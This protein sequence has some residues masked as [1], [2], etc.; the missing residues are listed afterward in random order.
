MSHH[1]RILWSGGL[2]LVIGTLETGA[3]PVLLPLIAPEFGV[4]TVSVAWV[5]VAFGLGMAS[6]ALTA[7]RIGDVLGHK[8][9]AV[10]G[11]A[12]EL[13]L[14]LLSIVSPVFWLVLPL[15]FLQG[16]AR[17]AH[18]NSIGALIMGA[19]PKE[20]R[21]RAV[22]IRLGLA[23]VGLILGPLYA[24]LVAN[25]L[26]W[27][28]PLLG[29]AALY[30]AHTLAVVLAVP[31]DTAAQRV[32][33]VLRRLD[34]PGALAFLVS[35][36]SLLYG[37]QLLR[38]GGSLPQAAAFVALAL[39]AF[40]AAMAFERR[41][42]SPA[43]NLQVLGTPISSSAFASLISFSA[44]FGAVTF[45]MPFFMQRG[46]G[47]T[48]A[49]SGG[50]L[51]TLN[52]V[53]VFGAPLMGHLADRGGTRLLVTVGS[54]LVVLGLLLASRLGHD[55]QAWQV[56]AVML[57]L[58]LSQSLFETPINRIFYDAVPANALASAAAFGT[59]GRQIGLALGGA[60]GA[61]LLASRADGSTV[62]GVSAALVT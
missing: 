61:A 23:Y 25:G 3:W 62:A 53:Q 58:G 37:A 50:V 14:L 8:R 51:V 36:A 46:L 24:G 47:W 18:I 39:A 12:L 34:W 19:Y 48:V 55:T 52:L 16:I 60:L 22:G 27:R 9:V 45:L 44:A 57:L 43:L 4:S 42:K 7:G 10:A 35:I 31:A 6:A 2:S 13:V 26:G 29:I 20:Q 41:A 21:G 30:V 1:R 5:L 32:M 11:F 28:A 40:A 59:V 15:R 56:V 17:S 38:R 54:A 33:P 49:V